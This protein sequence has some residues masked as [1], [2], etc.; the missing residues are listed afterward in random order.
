MNWAWGRGACTSCRTRA[1]WS[2]A[3]RFSA[4]GSCAPE[5]CRRSLSRAFAL[6]DSARPGPVH[7]ELPLDVI[8]AAGEGMD[9]R[10]YRSANKATA[11]PAAVERAA[12]MLRAARSPMVVLGGGAVGAPAEAQALVK[13]LGAPT[14]LTI[15]AKGLLPPGH[16]LSLGTTFPLPPVLA[17][18]RQ[19]RCGS[20]D[21]NGAGRNRHA[22]VRTATS[23][24]KAR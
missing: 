23:I 3:S 22:V 16:R 20:G 12:S 24:S 5:S 15:N 10:A 13:R 18:V 7:I 19:G 6:F 21:R 11:N 14:L 2:A 8:A 9:H 1:P 4:I 17:A